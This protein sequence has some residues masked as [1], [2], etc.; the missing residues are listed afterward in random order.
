MHIYIM[1]HGD[2]ETFAASDAERPLSQMGHDQSLKVAQRCR[3]N[4][5]EEFDLVLVSLIFASTT[6][7]ENYFA[8]IESQ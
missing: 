8:Y 1:R 7:M 4:G 2:A 5:Q 6:N 3:D